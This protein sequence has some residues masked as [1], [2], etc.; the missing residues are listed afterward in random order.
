M[1]LGA[2]YF[3]AY[4]YTMSLLPTTSAPLITPTIDT[5]VVATPVVSLTSLDIANGLMLPEA[6]RTPSQPFYTPLDASGGGGGAT[7]PTGP[8]GPTGA[9][10]ATGTGAT[11]ATGSIG[12]TGATGSTGT[13]G[14]A[15]ATGA[16]GATGGNDWWNYAAQ[17]TVDFNNQTL[18]NAKQIEDVDFLTFGALGTMSAAAGLTVNAVG[19]VNMTSGLST[20]IYSTAGSIELGGPI[21]HVVIGTDGQTITGVKGLTASGGVVD[22][23]GATSVLVPTPSLGPQ[24]TTK[25]YVDGAIS[26]AGGARPFITQVKAYNQATGG[27]FP[28]AASDCSGGSV[29]NITIGAAGTGAYLFELPGADQYLTVGTTVIVQSSPANTQPFQIDVGLG[30]A[31][32]RNNNIYPGGSLSCTV[33]ANAGPSGTPVPYSL[34]WTN[35]KTFSSIS[36]GGTEATEPVMGTVSFANGSG[37]IE[38]ADLATALISAVPPYGFISVEDVMQTKLLGVRSSDGIVPAEIAMALSESA[39]PPNILRMTYDP[40][41]SDALE[42][43]KEI[44]ADGLNLNTAILFKD[45]QEYFVSAN[46]SDASGNGSANSPFATVQK[47]IDV[48]QAVAGITPSVI[49]VMPGTYTENLSITEGYITIKGVVQSDRAIGGVIIKGSIGLSVGGANNLFNNQVVL[50]A[51]LIQGRILDVSTAQHTLIVDG[52]RIETSA[53]F[54]GSAISVVGTATDQRTYVNDCVITQVSTA[55]TSNPL[56]AVNVGQALIDG[57]GLTVRTAFSPVIDIGGAAILTRLNMTTLENDST[58]ANLSPLLQIRSSSTSFHNIALTSFAVS[59]T[60]PKSSFSAIAFNRDSVGQSFANILNN[61][62]AIAGT[63]PANNVIV[64]NG[65]T[66][67]I[68]QVAGNRAASTTASAVAAGITII[69][70]QYVAESAPTGP[71]GATGTTGATGATGATG[72]TG[73]VGPVGATGA[74]GTTGEVGPVGATGATGATGT[75]GE[76]G[77]VGATGATGTTGEVGP[78]GPTGTT[79]EVGPAGPTGPTGPTAGIDFV[80]TNEFY[81]ATN[82]DDLTGNGSML[83]PYFTI[84]A[85]I[86][87]ANA[88]TPKTGVAVINIAPGR[89]YTPIFITGANSGYIQLNGQSTSQNQAFGV[90]IDA[91]IFIQMNDGPSDLISRQ[92]IISGCQLSSLMNNTSSKDHTVIIQNCRFYPSADTNGIAIQ[93]YNTA[94]ANRYLIDNCEY[95]NDF[96][97]A[98]PQPCFNFQGPSTVSFSKCDIQ[99]PNDAP[100]VELAGTSYFQRLENCYLETQFVNPTTPLVLLSSSSPQFHS[101]GLNIFAF[102]DSTSTTTPA[103]LITNGATVLMVSNLFDLTGTNPSTGNV[104]QYTGT[105]PVLLYSNNSANPLYASGL[106]SGITLLPAAAV[107]AQPIKATTVTASGAITGGSVSAGSGTL[108]G[109]AITG[110]TLT[111]TG[112][113]KSSG[114]LQLSGNVISNASNNTSITGLNSIVFAGTAS[115]LTGLN[116]MT[117]TNTNS[118]VPFTINNN[119]DNPT[120]VM[121]I[122]PSST[123]I[124]CEF[125]INNSI[126]SAIGNQNSDP[127]GCLFFFTNG[128]DVLR[129]PS[130]TMRLQLNYS[131]TQPTLATSAAAGTWTPAATGAWVSGVAKILGTQ[132]ITLSNLNW[133]CVAGGFGTQYHLGIN[134]TLNTCVLNGAHDF[135]ISATYTR[136]RSGVSV[137]PYALYGCSY[138]IT[139][140][141]GGAFFSPLNGTSYNEANPAERITWTHGDILTLTITGLYVG[142]SP[143]STVTAPN[144]LACVFSPFLV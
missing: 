118:T 4:Y 80:A 95:T 102:R 125:Q 19:A 33:S 86:D 29:I 36:L 139:S 78:V 114:T 63:S 128:R 61:F 54:D 123:T 99:S 69:P 98:T 30:G 5:P 79:G 73:E 90:V 91:P 83:E 97:S 121:G 37:A 105:A 49:N 72:T 21:N 52:C 26:A 38:C 17:G 51:L 64:K 143:P 65:A 120:M 101:I 110:T 93:D 131:P 144:G 75:T 25:A 44:I 31:A 124:P 35:G 111:T 142:G 34:T 140:Q 47:A 18:N 15:G 96:P 74:T 113:I 8:A 1:F 16:T 40:S 71:T 43:N 135:I 112:A 103:I 58:S 107:G 2:H 22:L 133:P 28:I 14:P 116:S 89:Y 39:A 129:C 27:I 53:A 59:S 94:T 106:Q 46:G 41:G 60:T 7:G 81:V 10:G 127:R 82:G 141:A 137:G 134:G 66:T 3:L 48:A 32:F 76:V 85:A 100:L 62:F 42:V 87:A 119:T 12:P 109:G 23:S 108:S 56:I 84:Q 24:A 6:Y 104:I 45:A 9:T 70:A 55:T 11:G 68:I 67:A 88:I 77:P 115:S 132:T 117:I 57:C 122:S 20:T 126:V 92:V 136:T 138:P 13:V 50:S 130:T